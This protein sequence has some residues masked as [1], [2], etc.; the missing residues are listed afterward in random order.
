MPTVE[1]P[2]DVPA[3]LNGLVSGRTPGLQ[4][5]AV[6][7]Q[8]T[9]LEHCAGW[10]DL[11]RRAPVEP[12]T[13]LNAYSMSKTITAAA[14]LCLVQAGRVA[15]DDPLE[16]WVPA[17]P[18]GTGIVIRQLLAHTSGVPN[19]LPLGWVHRVEQHE[20]FD[21]AA[22]LQSVLAAHPRLSCPPGTKFRYSNIGYWLLGKVVEAA[23]GETFATYASRH[24]LAPLGIGPGQL[25]YEIADERRQ[26][27]GYLEKYSWINLGKRFLIDPALIGRYEGR[28]LRINRHYVN[29]LAFGGLV[30]SA[31][32]FGVFLQDQISPQS[33]LYEASTRELFYEPQ[34]TREGATVPM[35]PGWHVGNLD[36]HR[37][38]YKEGGGGGFRCLMRVYRAAG[39]ASIVMTNATTFNV[40]RCLDQVDRA[41]LGRASG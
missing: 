16:R 2:T 20:A 15:L 9:L 8:G 7:P 18:Y 4:Y 27:S 30:G 22:A 17:H 10:A 36:G 5:L 32:G 39:L 13:T 12:T 11:G 41:F 26:A 38:F 21:E 19:P 34:R 31:R 29:G 1:R 24:V 25:G 33:R 3:Y 23:S 40:H 28:W 14:V 35:T 37:V 6:G